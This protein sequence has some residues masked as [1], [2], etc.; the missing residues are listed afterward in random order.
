MCKW[1]KLLPLF[2][3]L[4]LLPIAQIKDGYL[5]EAEDIAFVTWQVTL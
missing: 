1:R 4:A 2:S 3:L 5:V